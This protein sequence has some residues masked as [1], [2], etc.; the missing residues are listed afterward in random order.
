[1]E[2]TT[3]KLAELA[4]LAAKAE[5]IP[6]ADWRAMRDIQAEL[7]KITETK[8]AIKLRGNPAISLKSTGYKG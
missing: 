8:C 4:A 5:S 3:N 2:L 6:Y 7:A 1:M